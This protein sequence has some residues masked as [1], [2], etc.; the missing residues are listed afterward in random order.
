MSQP[1]RSYC[2]ALEYGLPPTGGFGMGIDRVVMF[3]TDNY[4]IKEVLAFPMMK[5]VKEAVIGG[6]VE[7]VHED[8]ATKKDASSV[9]HTITV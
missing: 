8:D 4:S 9:A 6:R 1:S 5:E 2:K 3:L 7:V